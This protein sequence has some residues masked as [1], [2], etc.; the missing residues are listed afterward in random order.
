MKQKIIRGFLAVYLAVSLAYGGIRAAYLTVAAAMTPVETDRVQVETAA[1]SSFGTDAIPAEPK[2]ENPVV[3]SR[4]LSEES[5]PE[6]SA[7]PAETPIPEDSTEPEDPQELVEEPVVQEPEVLLGPPE[8]SLEEEP[9]TAPEPEETLEPAPEIPT[10][11]DYLSQLHCG[12]CG[13]NCL[14]SNPRC[15]TG[16]NKAEAATTEY[17]AEYGDTAD[18]W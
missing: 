3:P 6:D 8:M 11:E 4:N 14:L 5:P 9:E 13:R 17:Y 10:L 18:N 2:L 12:R 7:A 1:P 16:Q 15:R